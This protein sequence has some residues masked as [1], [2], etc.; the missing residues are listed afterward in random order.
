MTQLKHL[1][2]VEKLLAKYCREQD[3]P[4]GEI[5]SGGRHFAYIATLASGQKVSA[6]V[7]GSPRRPEME[8]VR[9]LARFKREFKRLKDLS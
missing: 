5:V 2:S 4:K 1:R 6:T 8:D 7:S 9:V 3:I